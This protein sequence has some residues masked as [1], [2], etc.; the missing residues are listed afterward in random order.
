MTIYD[1]VRDWLL[2]HPGCIEA[3]TADEV[4]R[5]AWGAAGIAC[6]VE[7]FRAPLWRAGYTLVQL[8]RWWRLGGAVGKVYASLGSVEAT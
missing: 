3:Q 6:S 1:R 8:G 5:K 2:T 7:E 4:I